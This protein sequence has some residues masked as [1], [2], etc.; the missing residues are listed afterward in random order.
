MRVRSNDG[1]LDND[2][3]HVA[4]CD[5]EADLLPVRSLDFVVVSVAVFESVSECDKECS[6]VA[7]IV[8]L[9]ASVP[10]VKERDA[11]FPKV[12]E[13]VFDPEDVV[14]RSFEYDAVDERER[15][16]DVVTEKLASAVADVD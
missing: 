9:R 7:D 8:R 5:L 4:E 16:G 1:E 14:V 15:V 13:W 12:P 2:L 11:D 10:P 6:L 3:T